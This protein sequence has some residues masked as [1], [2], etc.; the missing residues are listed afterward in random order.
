MLTKA[1]LGKDPCLKNDVEDD[2]DGFGNNYFEYDGA[3]DT[4]L[5]E[6]IDRAATP[7]KVSAPTHVLTSKRLHPPSKDWFAQLDPYQ[8]CEGSKEIQKRK[9]YKVPQKLLHPPTMSDAV[10]A[11]PY[12]DHAGDKIQSLLRLNQLPSKGLFDLNLAHI[13][14][15]RRRSLRRER[16]TGS[17]ELSSPVDIMMDTDRL[18][19]SEEVG[20]EMEQLWTDDFDDIVDE[21]GCSND[22]LEVRDNSTDFQSTHGCEDG[23][24]QE[25]ELGSNE[26]DELARRLEKVLS[27]DLSSSSRTSYESICQQYISDFNSGADLFAR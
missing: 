14:R 19:S 20:N 22:I 25:D 12:I 21:D 3:V 8:S 17:R 26:D 4:P 1:A 23:V 15:L 5:P 6:V 10:P 16:V 11:Y 24:A 27:D 2:D 18:H 9:N 7:R 13:L